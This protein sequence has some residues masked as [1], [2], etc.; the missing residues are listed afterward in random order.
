MEMPLPEVLDRLAIVRL[1]MERIGESHLKQEYDDLQKAIQ[2]FCE[3]GITIEQEWIDSLYRINGEI[4]D[5]EFDL[6]KGKEQELG[7]AEVGRRALLIREKNK[8]RISIKNSIVKQ[9]GLGYQD[10]KMN[11]ASA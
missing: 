4:W 7:L 2:E 10:V 1:K 6:R 5:L 3:R 11:H 8:Q 9:T